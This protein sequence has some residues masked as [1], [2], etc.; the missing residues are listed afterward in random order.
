MRVGRDAAPARV[1][2]TLAMARAA[3]GMTRRDEVP[4]WSDRLLEAKASDA[5][6]RAVVSAGASRFMRSDQCEWF[7]R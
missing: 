7:A 1:A 4:A 5:A 3:V 6:W 2:T